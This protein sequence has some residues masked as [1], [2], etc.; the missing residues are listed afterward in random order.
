[1]FSGSTLTNRSGNLIGA[2]Q[3][4]DRTARKALRDL[5]ALDK[6]FPSSKLLLHFEGKNG[7]DSAKAKLDGVHAPWHFY[8]PFDPDDGL[9]IDQME[10]HFERLVTNL[11]DKNHERSAFEAS[12]LAHAIVDG[13]TP[14]HH[15]PF[16]AELERLRGEGKETRTTVLKKVLIPGDTKRE[17]FAKNW[18][19]WGAKGLFTTHALFEW[20][21]TMIMAPMSNRIARPNRYE[22]KTVEHL[23]LSEYFKRVAREVA[24]LDMYEQFYKRGWTPKLAKQVRL[25]L[26]PRMA[27]TVTL[28]WYM[29][30]RDAGITTPEV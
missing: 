15:Y 18:E 17:L 24:L 20:G 3:K 22:L 8:D 13:L 2:H 21:A 14:A 6:G 25:E 16:E 29:A 5:L 28:A 9:L 4:I 26:A 27:K 12:W 7:P 30:A 10:A 23:G 11:K 1:M 19:M